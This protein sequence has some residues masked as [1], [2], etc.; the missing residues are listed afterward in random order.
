MSHDFHATTTTT[1]PAA[2]L[3]DNYPAELRRIDEA[4]LDAVREEYAD[5]KEDDEVKPC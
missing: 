3:P 1:I 4:A 5:A 2:S